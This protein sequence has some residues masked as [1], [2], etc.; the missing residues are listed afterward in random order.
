MPCHSTR[1]FAHSS[2]SRTTVGRSGAQPRS[3]LERPW[4]RWSQAK[5]PTSP[6]PSPSPPEYRGRGALNPEAISS[7][8]LWC[9]SP[10]L[11]GPDEGHGQYVADDME[12]ASAR[13][14]VLRQRRFE[15]FTDKL[16]LLTPGP[17]SRVLL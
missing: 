15:L 3:P 14:V 16:D 10:P 12:V 9:S 7:Q 17:G 4:P 5:T 8:L 11:L 6:S 2:T 1:C 13:D